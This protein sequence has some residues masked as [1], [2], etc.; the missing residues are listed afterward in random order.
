MRERSLLFEDLYQIVSRL[1]LR[2]H[3]VAT[4]YNTWANIIN[5]V[6]YVVMYGLL[7]ETRTKA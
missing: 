1:I 6:A 2:I 7:A 5:T 3:T 4:F